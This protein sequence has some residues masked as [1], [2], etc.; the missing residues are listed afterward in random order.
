MWAEK[1]G[2]GWMDGDEDGDG[3]LNFREFGL[4]SDA[5]SRVSLPDFEVERRA[6]GPG[7][8]F[9]HRL[10]GVDYQ[11]QRGSMLSGL[12][13]VADLESTLKPAGEPGTED[14]E[15]VRLESGDA[16]AEFY[17]IAVGPAARPGPVLSLNGTSAYVRGAL[18]EDALESGLIREFRFTGFATSRGFP[19]RIQAVGFSP[20]LRMYDSGGALVFD[21]GSAQVTGFE[22]LFLA[23]E[24]EVYR[25]ELSAFPGA[26]AG[27]YLMHY[28]RP[29]A[30][31]EALIVGANPVEGVLDE[32]SDFDGSYF[33]KNY[34]LEGAAPGDRI[35]VTMESN[36]NQG[37]FRPYLVVLDDEERTV[38]ES[39]G[40]PTTRTTVRF[41]VE[42]LTSYYVF[43]TSLNPEQTG[44]FTVGAAKEE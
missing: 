21:G 29:P 8:E 32:D 43:A 33:S 13:P 10:T 18:R 24:G 6:D 9:W 3:E 15:R 39:S 31:V 19:L 22:E 5:L 14:Y 35:A 23:E 34:R 26:T 1:A 16:E 42:E 17:Q 40:Q 11:V 30:A 44:V 20:R 38:A 2:V 27:D 7:L 12:S 37:G 25:G 41:R 28:P 4:G 36:S